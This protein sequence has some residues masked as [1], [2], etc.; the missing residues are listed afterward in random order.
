MTA[1]PLPRAAFPVTERWTYLNHAGVAPIPAPA[2]EAIAGYVSAA[3]DEGGEA[4]ARHEQREGEVRAAAAS[5]MGVDVADVAFV[6][7][8]TQGLALV[9]S[10]LDWS[11]GDRVVVPACEFPSNLYPWLALEELGVEVV[12]VEPVGEGDRLPVERFEDALR[13]GRV[14]VVAAS[15]VQFGRGW[16]VDVTALASLAHEHGALFVLDAIQGLGVLPAEFAEWG[17]DVSA[18][19][20]HKWLVGPEGFGVASVSSPAR[21]QLRVLEPGWNSVIHRQDWEN[22]DL[23]LD[24]TARRYEG[25]TQ[26]YAGLYGLGAS[27][28]LLLST[29]VDRIWSHVDSLCRRLAEGLA[30]AGATVLTDRS[31]G[32]ASG[33]VTFTVPSMSAKKTAAL[34]LE[35]AFAVRA[36]GGGVRASPHGYNTEDEIDAFVDAVRKL[37]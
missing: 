25:G 32:G 15:W 11:P 6:K 33:I 12:R 18:A 26:D 16:R 21:E 35:Q 34:L 19:D 22:R 24:P 3:R 1:P 14:R 20:G 27:I 10:G 7:N 28:D 31:G 13:V 9:A 30:E 5:L 23:V 36:R 29:G 2:A 17:V 4:Y 37:I 8:T